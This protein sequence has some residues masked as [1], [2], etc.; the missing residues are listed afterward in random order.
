MMICGAGLGF[1]LDFYRIMAREWWLIRK[2]RHILDVL[3][4]LVATFI[5]LLILYKS[6]GMQIRPI[7]FVAVLI[8]MIIYYCTVS[9]IFIPIIQRG[10]R[11]VKSII[12]FFRNII[13]ACIIRPLC[14]LSRFLIATTIF[15]CKLV[16]Q[17]F[18]SIWQ[19]FSSKE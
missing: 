5:I 12:Q 1:F 2:T 13:N 7:I 9:S 15:L 11:V 3:Y 14:L 10:I 17:L 18:Y 4:W 16:V 19:R 6:N 8:G